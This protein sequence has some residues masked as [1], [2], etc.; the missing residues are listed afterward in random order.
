MAQKTT[1]ISG[2]AGKTM[3]FG[4]LS[5]GL[6]T[7][8]FMN[9]ELIMSYFTK[10]GWYAAFP[11]GTAFLFSYV[12][13]AFTGNFWSLLGIESHAVKPRLEQPAPQKRPAQ[14]LRPRLHVS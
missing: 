8:V 6:Y 10:G 9:T 7:G 5:A 1:S 11:I 3:I 14:R 12:H 13:G 4:L 2:K